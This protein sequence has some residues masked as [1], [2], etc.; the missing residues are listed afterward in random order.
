MMASA[1]GPVDAAKPCAMTRTAIN[2]NAEVANDVRSENTA[3]PAN[4]MRYMRR[5]P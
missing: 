1:D 5:C 3:A 2:M 4:P